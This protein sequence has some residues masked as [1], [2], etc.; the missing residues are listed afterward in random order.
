MYIP[1][2]PN[3]EPHYSEGFV[4]RFFNLNEMGWV[5]NLNFFVSLLALFVNVG[6]GINR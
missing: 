5:A 6:V 2:A 1:F 3:D 4:V